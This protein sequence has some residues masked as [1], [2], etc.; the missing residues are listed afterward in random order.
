MFRI[1]YLAYYVKNL[2]THKFRIFLNFVHEKYNVP[3]IKIIWDC[4]V[5]SLKYN[6]SLLEFFQFGFYELNKTARKTFAGT[7]YMYEYQLIMNPRRAR[8]ILDDKTLFYKN[9]RKFILHKVADI[10]DLKADPGLVDS[11]INNPCGKIVF[12][13]FNGKCGQQVLIKS[14]AEFQK[15]DLVN[16]MIKNGFDL[17]EEYIVQH[18]QLMELSPSAVNTVRIFSQLDSSGKVEI[19][20][21]R[22][23]I[24]IN[25]FVD[26]MAAGNIAAPIDE[27]TGIITGPGVYSDITKPAEDKHPVTGTPLVGFK[28]P[29]WDEILR[30]VNEASLAHIQNRSIGWDIAV[31]EKGPDLIEGNHDWCKLVWQLPVKKGLKPILEK[32]S[33]EYKKLKLAQHA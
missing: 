6:I 17:A 23:R 28:I 33:N 21:C 1:I 4:I 27:A 31:T 18:P 20:G 25:S 12:K 5:S 29:F 9:Y 8:V 14:V 10:E 2:D 26:N 11:L 32:H 3:K 7:G 22:L 16:F 13:V 24:S 30:L 15:N 19:L